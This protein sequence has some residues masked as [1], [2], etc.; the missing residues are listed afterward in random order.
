MAIERT[1]A[2]IKPNAIQNGHVGEEVE[3]LENHADI[4]AGLINVGILIREFKAVHHNLAA[5]DSF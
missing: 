5:S 4:F 2:I 3:V 1:L